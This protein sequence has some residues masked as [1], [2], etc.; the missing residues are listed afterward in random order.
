MSLTI[1]QASFPSTKIESEATQMF[2]DSGTALLMAGH[3]ENTALRRLLL[4]VFALAGATAWA[5]AQDAPPVKLKLNTGKEIYQAACVACHGPDGKGMPDTTVAFEKP[6]TFPDFT[7]CD[8][9]TPELNKDWEATIRDGGAGRGF[10]RIMPSFGEALTSKEIDEVV[11]YVR[12]FCTEK[13]WPRGEFNVPL[14]QFTEKAFPEDEVIIT[15][16]L[17]AQGTPGLATDIISENTFGAR[18]QLEVDAPIDFVRS[19]PGVWHGGIGDATIGLKQVV[20]AN[21]HA[22]SILSGFGGLIVPSGNTAHGLG[23]GVT[24][25]ETFAAFA[26]LLPGESFVQ[27]QAGTDQPT[28]TTKAPRSLFWR[29]AMGKTFRQSNG[30]GRMWTPMVEVVA[31]KNFL[32]HTTPDWDIV[33]QFQVTLSA[34]QHVR[35]NLGTRIPVTNTSD[36]PV[37]V[38]FYVLWDWFDGSLLKGWK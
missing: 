32:P 33:P 34:R 10:S 9:T 8:Q 28:D 14:A 18:S 12:G 25:F 26:Q 11:R 3:W 1:T 27:L 19:A 17:N 35:L 7:R 23:S 21:L 29:S 5:A 15:S 6:S 31:N 36:R 16:K 2:G 30:L 24:Q 4:F 13:K 22:G 20:F 37:Q 38:V